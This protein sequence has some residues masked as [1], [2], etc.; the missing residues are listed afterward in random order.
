LI[1]HAI[2]AIL[3]IHSVILKTGKTTDDWG[4]D[5][6]TTSTTVTKVR[7]EPKRQ[8]VTNKDNQQVTTSAIMFV[9]CKLSSYTTFNIDD[10]INFNNKDYKI[11]SIDYA[12]T[13]RLHH[14]EI[15]LI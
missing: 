6:Y 13:D 12:Y 4:N 14:L 7:V 8:L 1:I 3:L 5:S 10:T 11:V 2:P 9:D 15:G